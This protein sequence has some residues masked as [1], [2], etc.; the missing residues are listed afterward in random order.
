MLL[1]D[2]VGVKKA[3]RKVRNILENAFFV[4]NAKVNEL[5]SQSGTLAQNGLEG[6]KFPIPVPHCNFCIV[7]WLKYTK[8][9]SLWLYHQSPSVKKI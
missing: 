7:H 4:A 5:E 8:V 6:A 3:Y 1:Q 9:Q 2:K